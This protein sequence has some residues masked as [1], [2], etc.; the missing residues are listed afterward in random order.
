MLYF[1][2]ALCLAFGLFGLGLVLKVLID[3][4]FTEWDV[5]ADVKTWIASL[6]QKRRQRYVTLDENEHPTE[7]TTRLNPSRAKASREKQFL[8]SP[9]PD[10]AYENTTTQLQ[11]PAS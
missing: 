6:S 11:I 2:F 7:L 5:I 8:A 9:D 10:Q 1:R 4:L 3:A